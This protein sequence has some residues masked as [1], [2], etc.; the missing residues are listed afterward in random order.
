MEVV[1]IDASADAGSQGSLRDPGTA[2]KFGGLVLSHDVGYLI[3]KTRSEVKLAVSLSPEEDEYSHSITIP[4]GWIK[5]IIPLSR[6][7][8]L[9]HSNDQPPVAGTPDRAP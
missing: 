6:P 8:E 2:A 4:R 7:P 1:W 5:S 3:S 9:H